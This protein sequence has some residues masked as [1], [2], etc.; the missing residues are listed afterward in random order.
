[1]R[2]VVALTLTLAPTTALNPSSSQSTSLDPNRYPR[3]VQA[4]VGGAGPVGA[5]RVRHSG[6]IA[7]ALLQS[8]PHI[9]AWG[10]GGG[11]AV[12]FVGAFTWPLV[13]DA[14]DSSAVALYS[15]GWASFMAGAAT[16]SSRRP[17][18]GGAAGGRVWR[19]GAVGARCACERAAGERAA[20]SARRALVA[21]RGAAA[22]RGGRRGAV[23][24]RRAVRGAPCAVAVPHGAAAAAGAADQRC[25]CGAVRCGRLPSGAAHGGSWGFAR[26]LR[27]SSR[28]RAC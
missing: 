5:C 25:C 10:V 22:G 11:A 12:R 18:A 28:R 7:Y 4:V 26:V 8:A 1:M 6:T 13:Q 2:P 17:V 19:C 9:A 27:L 16:A 3:Q 24:A 21:R 15:V 20:C 23:R 14:R